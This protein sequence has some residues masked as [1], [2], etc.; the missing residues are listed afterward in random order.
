MKII[1]TLGAPLNIADN[2][3]S[4]H[5]ETRL[6]ETIEQYEKGDLVIVTGSRCQKLDLSEAQVMSNWLLRYN[7]ASIMEERALNTIQNGIFTRQ[8][9]DSLIIPLGTPILVITSD[10]HLPR[11]TLIFLHYFSDMQVY[12]RASRTLVQDIISASE[13]KYLV[14]LVQNFPP[15]MI[16]P[17]T[18]I[19][20]VKR[21]Y[22][23]GVVEKI[24][25][26]SSTDGIENTPLHWAASYGFT[27][28]C[29]YLIKRGAN[30]NAQNNNGL[31]PLNFA[32]IFGRIDI[33]WMLL[34]HKSNLSLESDNFRWEGK[35]TPAQTMFYLRKRIP[36]ESFTPLVLML[37]KFTDKPGIFLIRHAQSKENKAR[38]EKR[39]VNLHDVAL[40]GEGYTCLEKINLLILK[41]KL[42]EGYDIVCS[43]LQRTLETCRILT[44]GTDIKPVIDHR[45]S[46]RLNNISCTGHTREDLEPLYNCDFS[47]IPNKWWYNP[48]INTETNADVDVED[49]DILH[50]RIFYFHD[51]LKKTLKRNTLVV[52]HGGVIHLM[53]DKQVL[54]RNCD[55]FNSTHIN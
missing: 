4:H 24:S 6:K 11:A 2:T 15:P 51:E 12:F 31:I 20:E 29:E 34:K 27:R 52:T 35:C 32:L 47:R 33:T 17:I 18:L 36:V 10:F 40:S 45:I 25:Q 7:I 55:V 13:P 46:E 48:E 54:A 41:Y 21:G 26:L 42:L 50:S 30:V 43:P 23:R 14:H 22:M 39:R 9:I 1:I 5:L 19:D 8:L 3:P 38:S 16:A 44:K 28:I 37:N 53:F 49:W